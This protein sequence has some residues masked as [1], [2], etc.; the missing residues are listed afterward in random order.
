M[1]VC[2]RPHIAFAVNMLERFFSNPGWAHWFAIKKVMRYLQRTKYF[3]QVYRKIDNLDLLV[4]S[5]SDFAGCLDTIKLTSG[6]IFMLA[7]GIVSWKSKKQ[8][9][10]AMYAME[11]EFT[12]FETASYVV[13]MKT[14]LTKL[15]VFDFVSKQ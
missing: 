3:M 2:T 6:Y 11:V 14:F 15:Q 13:W 7:G 4:H 8:S 1:Y 9:I 10:T 12:C 5:D